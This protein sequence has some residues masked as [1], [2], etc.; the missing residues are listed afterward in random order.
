MDVYTEAK[1]EQI[2]KSL[3]CIVEMFIFLCTRLAMIVC[4]TGVAQY[5]GIGQL[6][7]FS[8]TL[9]VAFLF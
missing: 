8:T 3:H 4:V 5:S 7:Y 6:L 9:T 1:Q 2:T